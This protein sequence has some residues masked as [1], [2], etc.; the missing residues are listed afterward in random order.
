MSARRGFTLIEV[1]IAL[2]IGS[3]V[4]TLAYA[5]LHAGMDVQRRVAEAREADASRTAFR[6]ML[7]DALRHAVPADARDAR[8]LHAD[9]NAAGRATSLSFISRGISAPLGGAG[10]WSV[11]LAPDAAGVVFTA[12][13]LDSSRT[14]LRMVARG[15]RGMVVRFLAADDANWRSAWNDVTRLPAAVEVRFLDGDG[16]DAMAVLVARTAPVGGL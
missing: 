2:V 14:P 10:L 1:M 7:V 4:V 16:R 11:A 6:A 3:V 15:V 5:T 13:S 12:A 9:A 8:G